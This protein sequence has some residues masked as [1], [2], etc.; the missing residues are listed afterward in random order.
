MPTLAATALLDRMSAEA[1]RQGLGRC[2]ARR[3][4][5]QVP[6]PLGPEARRASERRQDELAQVADPRRGLALAPARGKRPL[7]GPLARRCH[8][9]L[10]HCDDRA[11]DADH[12]RCRRGAAS[13]RRPAHARHAGRRSTRRAVARRQGARARRNGTTHP[14]VCGKCGSATLVKDGGWR[15]KCWG[16]GLDWFPR[17]DPVVIMLVTDGERCI[18]GARAPLCARACTR[19]W[20]ASSSPARTSSTPSAARCWRKPASR[21][22]AC[23]YH[24]KPALAVPALADDGL[25]R[26]RRDD[27]AHVDTNELVDARWFTRDEALS[28]LEGRPSRGADRPRQ[29]RDRPRPREGV[30]RRQDQLS[31]LPFRS[32]CDETADHL[33]Q[34]RPQAL[35]R[36]VPAREPEARRDS[37][38]ASCSA[39]ATPASRISICPT[40]PACSTTP[41]TSS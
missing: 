3:R 8:P 4:Q 35:R 29:A 14:G 31:A 27:R 13:R 25:H 2:P 16:C 30:R 34:R 9:P 36:S 6:R 19:R 15:R 12:C 7:F 24:R 21:S 1:R 37:A 20:P 28:M 40:T 32:R 26:A 18:L 39:T 5:C 38:P 23:D 11:S 10:R 41:A 33:L 22:V 17:T